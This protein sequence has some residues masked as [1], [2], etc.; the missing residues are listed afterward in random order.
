M[1]VLNRKEVQRTY[2]IRPCSGCNGT[3][4]NPSEHG[5]HPTWTKKKDNR[6]GDD[7]LQLNKQ[8]CH[9]ERRNN[10]FNVRGLSLR[11]HTH[12]RDRLQGR[13]IPA[14]YNR[15]VLS[16]PSPRLLFSSSTVPAHQ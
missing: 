16:I 10:A 14:R 5:I 4:P 11:Q 2:Q 1:G 13:D 15:M 8:T 12:Q 7:V 6:A 3:P 9:L